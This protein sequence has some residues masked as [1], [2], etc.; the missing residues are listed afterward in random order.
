M[1]EAIQKFGGNEGFS[2]HLGV[3]MTVEVTEV[4][5]VPYPMTNP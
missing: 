2:I 1:E 5:P 3:C 4:S